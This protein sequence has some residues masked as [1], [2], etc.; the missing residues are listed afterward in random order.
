MITLP[1]LQ[2][3]K[4]IA[5]LFSGGIASTMTA[6]LA[7]EKY[8][9]NN[10]IAVFIPM[11]D[12]KNSQDTSLQTKM[13]AFTELS[14]KLNI[15]NKVMLLNVEDY[16]INDTDNLLIDIHRLD[17]SQS[18]I[19]ILANKGYDIQNLI[20]G[21]SKLDA[22]IREILIRD[23]YEDGVI[24][25]IDID[26]TREY[27]E[28]NKDK[29]PE[30]IAHKVLDNY[31]QWFTNNLF[32]KIEESK[33]NDKSLVVFP[34]GDMTK[35]QIVALYREKGLDDLLLQTKSCSKYLTHCGK[36]K[37]CIQREIALS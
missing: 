3:N 11:T 17:F 28:A 1:N 18:L 32:Y 14:E 36:C 21:N 5:V 24:G 7:I 15:T 12:I 22:E 30:I 29:Y 27:I 33:A 9:I 25:N 10:V 26:G 35:K 31:A 2:P 8:G 13:Q 16:A 6:V 37:S 20:L 4:Q 34:F 23:R 19:T